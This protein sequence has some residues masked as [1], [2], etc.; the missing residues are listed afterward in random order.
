MLISYYIGYIILCF[1]AFL[2]FE[3]LIT[4]LFLLKLRNYIILKRIV[5][6]AKRLKLN[7]NQ[8]MINIDNGLFLAFE[9]FDS[10]MSFDEVIVQIRLSF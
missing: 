6:M 10:C 8:G 5:R 3:L 7:F 1:L 9:L 2:P 4:P